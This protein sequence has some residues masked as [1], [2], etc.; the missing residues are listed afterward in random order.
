M[1]FGERNDQRGVFF[2]FVLTL[3]IC[4]S[5]LYLVLKKIV[6]PNTPTQS[7]KIK[8]LRVN[9]IYSIHN[10]LCQHNTWWVEL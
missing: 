1:K 9:T 2:F 5:K 4:K 10:H 6:V 8:F 3:E 7:I